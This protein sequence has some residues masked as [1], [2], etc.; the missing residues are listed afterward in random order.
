MKRAWEIA[1]EAAA[2]FGGKA[3][4]YIRGGAV[5]QAY[6]EVKREDRM[7]SIYADHLKNFA[8]M[9]ISGDEFSR[10]KAEM[11]KKMIDSRSVTL[12]ENLVKLIKKHMARIIVDSTQ[13]IEGGTKHFQATYDFSE[14]AKALGFDSKV[15]MRQDPDNFFVAR[16]TLTVAN[17]NG[18]ITW[19][20]GH[21]G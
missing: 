3:V 18:V 2:K 5:R 4:E 7:D 20:N 15:V 16:P 17:E 21:I 8:E 12:N 9:Q 14:A 6:D 10:K 19:Y 11:F 13:V 1:R